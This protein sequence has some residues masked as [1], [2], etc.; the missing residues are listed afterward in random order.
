MHL[1]VAWLGGG[2][3]SHGS[4]DRILYMYHGRELWLIGDLVNFDLNISLLMWSSSNHYLH[5]YKICNFH[6]NLW[7][8]LP[9]SH[10]I[11]FFPSI[12]FCLFFIFVASWFSGW[13]RRD[14]G[15]LGPWISPF[16]FPLSS[17]DLF[18]S[19]ARMVVKSSM[20]AIYC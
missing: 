20:F 10:L 19:L 15:D 14:S 13:G 3:I 2:V 18:F 11:L 7:I 6:S 1:R 9:F 5:T 4:R 8:H 12:F 17:W 16:P